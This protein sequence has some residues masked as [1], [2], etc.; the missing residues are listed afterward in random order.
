M[1][2]ESDRWSGARESLQ[3]VKEALWYEWEVFRLELM[4]ACQSVTDYAS[5]AALPSVYPQLSRVLFVV[6]RGGLLLGLGKALQDEYAPVEGHL[7]DRLAILLNQLEEV[8]PDP[9]RRAA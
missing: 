9:S 4:K 3:L 8:S 7:P 2:R 6:G 1:S 5:L